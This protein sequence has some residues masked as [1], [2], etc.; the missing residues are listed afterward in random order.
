MALETAPKKFVVPGEGRKPRHPE[1]GRNVAIEGEWIV[2]SPRLR[3][4]LR[5]GDL[6]ETKPAKKRK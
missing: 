2:D 1:L 5:D 6:V 4:F 3:R